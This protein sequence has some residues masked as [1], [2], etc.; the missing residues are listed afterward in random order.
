MKRKAW[1][2]FILTFL[3]IAL[4]L[5]LFP[6]NLFDGIIVVQQGWQKASIETRLSLSYFIGMGLNEGDLNDITDFY[7]TARGWI[8]VLLLLIGLPLLV[9]LRMNFRK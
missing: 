1:L 4:P 2:S 9:A 6:I 8:M 5:F 3:I 7:L